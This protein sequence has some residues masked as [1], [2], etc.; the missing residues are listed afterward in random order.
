MDI[1]KLVIFLSD[2][3]LQE[4]ARKFQPPDAPIKNLAVQAT[5]EGVRVSG[6]AA[7]PMLPLPF[8]SVWRPEV[9]QE[10]RVVVQLVGL[11][12]AGF[13]ATLLRSLVLG[14]LKDAIK[15][16]FIE[17]TEEAIVV[18][19]QEFVRREKLPI[20]VRFAIQSVRCVQAG[21]VVEAGLP[22]SGEPH[23]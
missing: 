14:L 18:D 11:T 9:T 2:K 4:L 10:G 19:V 21:V 16:P 23:P 1:Q 12:A 22:V 8:E 3:E 6:E 20:E 17:T 15:E 13:P 7:T 5:P